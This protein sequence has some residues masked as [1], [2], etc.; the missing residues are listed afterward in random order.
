MVIGIAATSPAAIERAAQAFNDAKLHA[1]LNDGPADTDSDADFPTMK[2]PLGLTEVDVGYEVCA[3][4]VFVQGIE[5]STG[6]VDIDNF[7]K[8]VRDGWTLAIEKKLGC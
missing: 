7:A 8:S 2:L 6:W 5:L 1:H 3:G 4:Q